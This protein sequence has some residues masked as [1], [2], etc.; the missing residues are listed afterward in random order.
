MLYALARPLTFLILLVSFLIAVTL[1]GWV[2]ALAAARLG[3]GSL[4][5][6][7]RLRPDP[8]RHLDPFGSVA[9]LI[10]GFGWWRPV[11]LPPRGGSGA[12]GGVGT[13]SLALACLAGPAV[14]LGV[15]ALALGLFSVSYGS[16]GGSVS[17]LLQGADVGLA[18]LPTALLLAG[19][20]HLYVGLLALVPL[21]PLPGA[22]LLFGLAPRSGGWQKAEHY[23]VEQNIGV[24][25]VLAL[26]LVPLGGPAPLLPTVLDSVTGGPLRSLTG[27]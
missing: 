4:R 10:A 22:R 2:S 26:M 15:A 20:M 21:P 3:P 13:G 14:L 17:Q 25:L 5:A 24:V 11:E 27:G 6:E 12:R 19:V 16:V 18:V 7:G 8:R 1:G 23:L 9:A